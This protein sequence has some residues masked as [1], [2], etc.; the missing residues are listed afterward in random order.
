MNKSRSQQLYEINN[1][2]MVCVA[3]QSNTSHDIVG[4]LCYCLRGPYTIVAA[5]GHGAYTLRKLGSSDGPTLKYHAEDIPLRP[6]AIQPVEPLDG[7]DLHYLNHA[8]APISHPM[9]KVFNIG[10]YNNVWFSQP[11]N[12]SPPD[13]SITPNSTITYPAPPSTPTSL[14]L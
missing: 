2:V 9:K 1:V 13:F 6:P 3:V 7:P 12:Y 14:Q 11:T 10:L 5:L 8:R 4:K